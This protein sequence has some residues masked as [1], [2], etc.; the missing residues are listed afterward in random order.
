[1]SRNQRDTVASVIDTLER[2]ARDLTRPRPAGQTP[3]ES[4]ARLSQRL[5][6]LAALLRR[7]QE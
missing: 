7:A 4:D 2:I 1:M 5:A 3:E 6:E